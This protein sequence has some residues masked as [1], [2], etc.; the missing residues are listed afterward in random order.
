[1]YSPVIGQF[2]ERDPVE[3]DSNLYRYC[4]DNSVA[5]TDPSGTL[6]WVGESTTAG[7]HHIGES[8]DNREEL[9][10]HAAN[11]KKALDE[12]TAFPEKLFDE[13]VKLGNVDYGN[14]EVAFVKFKGSKQ[15]FRQMIERERNTAWTM[16]DK[17]GY[18]GALT[19]IVTHAAQN[20]YPY[21]EVDLVAHGGE[22]DNGKPTGNALFNSERIPFSQVNRDVEDIRR[23]TLQGRVKSLQCYNNPKKESTAIIFHPFNAIIGSDSPFVKL[24]TD[25][26]LGPQKAA[27]SCRIRLHMPYVR[28]LPALSPIKPAH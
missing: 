13:M 7:V 4:F 28:D 21:D 16:I 10:K 26:Q 6:V 1:M 23:N 19:A 24:F 2:A 18:K 11:V 17:G 5:Y 22:D 3:S 9:K 27:Q 20:K 8:A 25:R 12:L 14:D 15:Q